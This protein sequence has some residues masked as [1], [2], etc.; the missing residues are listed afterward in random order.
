[1]AIKGHVDE[2]QQRLDYLREGTPPA[3]LVADEASAARFFASLRTMPYLQSVDVFRKDGSLFAGFARD[4]GLPL[5]QLS[6]P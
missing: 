4:G 2:I 1:V 5:A 6:S 3:L